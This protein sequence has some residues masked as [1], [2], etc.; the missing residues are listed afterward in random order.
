MTLTLALSPPLCGL[1]PGRR[2]SPRRPASRRCSAAP[3]PARPP[4]STP[5]RACCGPNDGRITLDGATL[6]DT[7]TGQNLP[8]HRRRIGYVFQDARLF[9]HLTVRQNLLYGRWFAPAAPRA[10]AWRTSPTCSASPRSWTAA[11]A[12]CRAASGSAS[13][14]A[15]RILSNPRLLLMDEPL[16]ALD[17]ARKAEILPYLERLRDE[18][19]PAHPLRQPFAGRGRA[20]GHHHRPAGS[21]PRHRSGSGRARSCQTPQPPNPSACARPA[22]SCTPRSQTQDPDGLTRLATPAGPL[23]LPRV[24]AATGTH[25]APAHPGPGHH[26]VAGAA[27]GASRRSTSCP[28]PSRRSTSAKAPAR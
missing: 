11:P 22:P 6:L 25:P 16:A 15:A 23:W 24:A 12:P 13:P 21:G 14:L 26:A 5:S 3:V 27:A 18:I 1:H 28:P 9:P 2:P 4:S 20:A 19:A 8:P 7:A 10:P 17:D